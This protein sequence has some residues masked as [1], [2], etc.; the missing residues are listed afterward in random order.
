MPTPKTSSAWKLPLCVA[1]VVAVVVVP[2]GGALG[3]ASMGIDVL[4]LGSYME[5]GAVALVKYVHTAIHLIARCK[6]S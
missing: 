2:T 5:N 4:Q 3:C 6:I 1:M